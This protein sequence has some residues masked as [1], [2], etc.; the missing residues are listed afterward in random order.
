MVDQEWIS[1]D[2]VESWI[3]GHDF[4]SLAYDPDIGLYCLGDAPFSG[5]VLHRWRNGKLR[6]V[7]QYAGGVAHGVSVGWYPDGEIEFYREM[8]DGVG[9]GW[10][11]EWSQSGVKE[12]EAQYIEGRKVD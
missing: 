3:V 7:A 11:I 9:H 2:S 10:H 1:R 6:A 4:A 8:G 5:N 12:S